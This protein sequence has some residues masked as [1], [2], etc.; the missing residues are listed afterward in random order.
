MASKANKFVA[1]TSVAA[2]GAGSAFIMPWEGLFTKPYRDIVG[3][4]TVCYGETAADHVQMKTYTPQEC[5]D[6]LPKHLQKGYAVTLQKCIGRDVPLSV[7]VLGLSAAYNLGAGTVCK[8]K[9]ARAAK[10]GRWRDACSGLKGYDHAGSY[11]IKGLTNRRVAEE[12]QCLK[13]L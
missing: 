5:K 1:Y 8:S 3:V 9:Y 10:E 7:A 12:K 4:W 11:R 13:G 6:M 2:I